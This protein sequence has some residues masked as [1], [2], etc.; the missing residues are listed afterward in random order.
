MSL[1]GTDGVR[2]RANQYPM[3]PEMALKIGKAIGFVFS[4]HGRSRNIVVIGKDT[5]VSGYMFESA[6]VAGITSMGVDALL[7]GPIPTPGISFITKNM[8][9]DAGVVISASH[10][11]YYDNGIK[12]FTEEGLKLNDELEKRIE[13]L[14][15]SD[16]PIAG[17]TDRI[18]KAYRVDDAIGRYI[19]HLKL[20]F[21][22]KETLEG[23]KIVVDCANGATYKVAPLVFS[24][25]GA[26]VV[27]INCEPDGYNINEGCGAVHP[28]VMAKKVVEV[29]ADL[30]VAFD[31]DGDR[32]IFA[33]EM[34]RIVDG[35]GV[36]AICGVEMKRRGEL[37]KDVVVSTIMASMGLQRVLEENGIELKRTKVGDRFV[38]EEMERSGAI[39]G[40]EHSGHVIFKQFAN[41]GD[42]IVT[43]LRLLW[44][45]KSTGMSLSQ[46]VDRWVRHFPRVEKSLAINRKIPLEGTDF[47]KEIERIGSEVER[48]AGGRIVV[49]YSGTEHKLRIMVEGEDEDKV[50]YYADALVE[51]AGKYLS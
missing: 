38:F 26:E 2:G 25:L 49:R 8:R 27:A 5:R 51:I 23:L 28:E 22:E 11:P 35:D 34:G 7:L 15:L 24:E 17:K 39:L 19:V 20:C 16:E 44:V 46:L 42:G 40:G 48:L 12:I 1:F 37:P 30:G 29:G 36:L 32:A 33:D 41:T 18:G 9:A 14:V 31:G 43:A 10:N 13:E 47:G 4:N 6:L 3:T 21:P 50:K 45:M